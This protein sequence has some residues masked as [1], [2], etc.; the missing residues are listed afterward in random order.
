MSESFLSELAFHWTLYQNMF[1]QGILIAVTLSLTGVLV[2]ARN[3][4]FTLS[5]IHI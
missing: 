5:L 3:Q 2:V 1:A 4:I